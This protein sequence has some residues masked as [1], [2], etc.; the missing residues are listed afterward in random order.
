MKKVM[1][2][3][4][5]AIIFGCRVYAQEKEQSGSKDFQ[6]FFGGNLSFNLA[7][8][9]TNSDHNY[10]NLTFK[11]MPVIG[12][13]VGEN[14]VLGMAIEFTM[15]EDESP[16]DYYGYSN[17]QKSLGLSVFLRTYTNLS[18]KFKLYYEPVLGRIYYIQD[19]SDK[20][21]RDYFVGLNF[22]MLYFVKSRFSVEVKI[23]SAMYENIT[24]KDSDYASNVFDLNYD[25]IQPNFGL[26]FY[27]R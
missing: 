12:V 2:L 1:F 10:K 5:V 22:G 8:E 9:K 14:V 6:S 13:K 16:P 21:I 20:D 27:F 18:E 23:A 19:E 25:I 15:V 26:K 11:A 24:I 17:D 4:I 3:M 7:Q